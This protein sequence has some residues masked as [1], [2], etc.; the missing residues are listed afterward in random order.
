M[1]LW[2]TIARSPSHPARPSG[3]ADGDEVESPLEALASQGEIRSGD[4]RGE[5]V[6]ERLGQPQ[7]PVD[8]VPAEA[9]RHL[10]RTQLAR[11]EETQDLDPR[12]AGLEQ[13]PVL[14]DR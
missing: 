3:M 8:V 2:R 1:W 7:S 5:A 10:V 14:L 11:M 4:R 6:I 9:D 13:G 12:E